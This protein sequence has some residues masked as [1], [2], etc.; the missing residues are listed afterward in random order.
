MREKK[1]DKR[2]IQ[3]A[4]TKSKLYEI[5]KRL[6]AQRGFSDVSIENIT[7]EAGITKGA[8]YVHFASKDALIALLIADYVSQ[9]DTVYKAFADSLPD[10][11]PCASAL[12]ALADKIAH[13]LAGTLGYDSMNKVYQLLLTGDL[14]SQPVREYT[15]ELYTLVYN[16]L[17][18][19]VRRGEIV[20][21]LS[22]DTL[23]RHF[24][25]ALRGV[26]FEWC[27]QYP[28]L[29]LTEQTAA[30]IQLLIDGIKT[31]THT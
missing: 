5:A 20:S 28:E 31:R 8:F 9:A 12:L 30:H 16:L 24:V 13:T 29:D 26:T 1:I 10:D 18:K 27:V 21:P 2:K 19:G 4:Q 15:R 11:M 22:L 6:F 14:G 7:D 23:S 17:E 3:G 25:M